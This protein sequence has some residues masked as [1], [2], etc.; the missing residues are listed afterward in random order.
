MKIKIASIFFEEN[1]K[2]DFEFNLEETV[3]PP[4]LNEIKSD[5]RDFMK[6]WNG[7]NETI[8]KIRFQKN[9]NKLFKLLVF[10]IMSVSI[11]LGTWDGDFIGPIIGS[12]ILFC[13]LLVVAYFMIRKKRKPQFPDEIY[14]NCKC[15]TM[16]GFF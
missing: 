16:F 5:I 3:I 7:T 1:N 4:I 11:F 12:S 14:F 2:Y 9:R 13:I 15:I 6:C 8:H 10:F